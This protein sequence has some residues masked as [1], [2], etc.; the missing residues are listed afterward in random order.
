MALYE[1]DKQDVYRFADFLG[2]KVKTQGKDLQ[3]RICPYCHSQR[4][5]YTFGIDLTTGKYQCLRASCGVKGNM[6]TL[7]RDFDFSLGQQ[8]DEYYR[9]KKHYRTFKT[10]D[11]PIEPKPQA[12]EYLEGRKI[13]KKI[14]ERYEITVQN[15][16]PNVLVFPFYDESGEMCFVKYRKT[17]FEKGKDKAKE[18]CEK[19]GKPILFGMKQCDDSF[20][21]LVICEGQLDSLSVAA[22]GIKNVVSVPIG[23]KGFTWIPYCWEW[24]NKWKEIVVFGDYERGNISLLAEIE[25]RFTPL[26]KHV[27]ESDYKDCKDAN[28][29]LQ[30]YGAEQVRICVNDAIP[31]PVKRVIE[32]ADVEPINLNDIEKLQTHI[33]C[34]DRLLQGGLPFGGVVILTGKTGEG[35]ST[36]AG[37]IMAEA[38]EQGYTCLAYSGELPKAMFQAGINYQVAGPLHITEKTNTFGDPA[39][40][41][42]LTNQNLIREWYRGKFFLYDSD[43]ISDE[44]TED[45]TKTIE[46]SIQR[47]GVRVVLLD[48]LMTAMDM[49]ALKGDEYNRQTKFVMRLR[50]IAVTHNVLIL[51]V[52]HKRKNGISSNEND[53]VAG[54]SNLTN[55]ATVVIGYG[56]D[57]EIEPQ[58]RRLTVAKNRLFGVR[59]TDGFV[60]NFSQK[61]RRIWGEGDDLNRE[62][63]WCT[64]S[65]VEADETPFD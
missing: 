62:M 1:F 46:E 56:S 33:K 63:S 60:L 31:T 32:L 14:A 36:L 40:Y 48:N 22:A 64:D 19:G 15:D 61:S 37:Q 5:L 35:K 42:S 55:L 17:D 44:E 50:R 7:A 53:E 24:M 43:Y 26:I 3:F 45:L 41:L 25:K 39:F 21:R 57:K 49:D 28:E 38:I 9:P 51:L 8:V 65:F 23:A 12:I 52:A 47:H 54:S 6:I 10:P 4:D 18:W 30:K 11:K 27:K 2:A 13:P 34:L 16:N 29:I 59:N 58:E 20:D